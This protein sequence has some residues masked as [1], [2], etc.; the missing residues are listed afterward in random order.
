MAQYGFIEFDDEAL[1]AE[2]TEHSSFRRANPIIEKNSDIVIIETI[3]N[4]TIQSKSD[5]EMQSIEIYDLNGRIANAK[6]FINTIDI[7]KLSASIYVL[8]IQYTD[9]T[10]AT[11][12]YFK[13]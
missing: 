4:I 3:D 10:I 6:L 1:C 2:N 8:K 11:K 12:Y 5:K 13:K 7:S 9:N